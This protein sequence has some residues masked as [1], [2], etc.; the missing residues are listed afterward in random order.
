MAHVVVVTISCSYRTEF[1]GFLLIAG[2]LLLLE[3][4]HSSLPS[5]PFTGPFIISPFTSF[6]KV[7][8]GIY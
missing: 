7:F 8:I 3:I 4:V 5:G 6:I 2:P 1:P